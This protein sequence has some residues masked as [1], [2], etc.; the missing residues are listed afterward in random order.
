MDRG[1]HLFHNRDP[2]LMVTSLRV[3]FHDSH[4]ILLY[5]KQDLNRLSLLWDYEER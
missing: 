2:Q 1:P 5:V 4:P 3:T